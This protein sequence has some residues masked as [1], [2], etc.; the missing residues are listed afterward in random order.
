MPRHEQLSLLTLAP[1]RKGRCE[2]NVD[3]AVLAGYAAG[4]VDKNLDAAAVALART[5]A[6]AT[7]AQAE[8]GNPW[9]I[10]ALARELRVLL[11]RLRLDPVSRGAGDRDEFADFLSD[12][13]KPTAAPVRDTT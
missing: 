10:A 8:A 3:R 6:R 7:D 13:A 12:L 4:T 5:L 11:E 1:S 9:A 2:S